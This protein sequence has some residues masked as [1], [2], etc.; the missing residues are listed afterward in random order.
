MAGYKL[1]LFLASLCASTTAFTL[2]GRGTP[3]S[4]SSA[5]TSQVQ[6]QG[7]VSS[8]PRR[9]SQSQTLLF[10]LP[11]P[12]AMEGDW[13]AYLDEESTGLIYYFNGKTGE[14]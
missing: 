1:I 14:S 9:T 8:S 10:N 7:K 6:R 12:L 2:P 5:T 13:T 11:R 4:L 3:P